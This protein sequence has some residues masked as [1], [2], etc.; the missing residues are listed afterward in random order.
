MIIVIIIT[1]CVVLAFVEESVLGYFF[2]SCLRFNFSIVN[3]V[4]FVHYHVVFIGIFAAE[5]RML[6]ELI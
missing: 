3:Y 2:M 4:V 5:T 1:I 6:S